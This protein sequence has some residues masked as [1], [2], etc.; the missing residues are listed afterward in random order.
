MATY[1]I[2]G[3]CGTVGKALAR[4]ILKSH[5][6]AE[7]V[8]VDTNETE[9]FFINNEFRSTGRFRAYLCDIRDLN[10]LVLRSQK[11]DFFFHTA[12]LKHVPICEM[13]PNQAVSTNIIGTQNCIQAAKSN[14]VKT[15]I[16]TSSDKAVNPTNVMGSTKLVG[17]RLVTAAAENNDS[18]CIFAS[19]RFG[20]VVGSRGSVI[21]IFRKQI[22]RSEK[23]T[24][25]HPEMTRF[26]M[27]LDEA[28]SLVFKSSQIAQNGDV[29]VTKMP[30][31]RILDIAQL[32]L[33]MAQRSVDEYEIIGIKPGEK[34]FE[35]LNN[36]EEVDRTE[37]AADFLRI[38]SSNKVIRGSNGSTKEYNSANI[39]PV[40]QSE[41]KALL[42]DWNAI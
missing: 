10:E 6:D 35:E 14:N 42:I 17:E 22:E 26:V 1:F 40:T 11:A 32:F 18:D 27:S 12:A 31:A 9:V 33:E 21:P 25:T 30:V 8:G 37:D 39:P 34:L 29:L 2:T 16:F 4:Y 24:I 36:S 13:S 7:V 20:N 28:V 19:T 41:L 38:M 3:I 5:Q 15:F 23:L